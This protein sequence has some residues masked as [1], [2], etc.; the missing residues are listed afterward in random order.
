MRGLLGDRFLKRF[1]DSLER[2]RK[3]RELTTEGREAEPGAENGTVVNGTAV[4]ENEEV[5]TDQEE[6]NE[7]DPIDA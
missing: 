4:I 5:T 3:H 6:A 1:A 2:R 7:Q